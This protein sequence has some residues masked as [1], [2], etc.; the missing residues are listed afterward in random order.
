MQSCKASRT[1]SSGKKTGNILQVFHDGKGDEDQGKQ[2]NYITIIFEQE[3]NGI[4]RGR[5]EK[6]LGKF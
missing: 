4:L 5:E 6:L 2:G 1:A 3:N